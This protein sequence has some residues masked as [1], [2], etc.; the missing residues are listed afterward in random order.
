MSCW[1]AASSLGHGHC[2]LALTI[3][4]LFFKCSGAK[5]R[6][7]K[8]LSLSDTT[9]VLDPLEQLGLITSLGIPWL[10][11]NSLGSFSPLLTHSS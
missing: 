6:D 7:R 10:S 1:L 4:C 9:S 5:L 8:W 2:R 3:V 11:P